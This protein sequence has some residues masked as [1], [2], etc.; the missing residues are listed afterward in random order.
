MQ[1]IALGTANRYL[2]QT[3]DIIVQLLEAGIIPVFLLGKV[4]FEVEPFFFRRKFIF[5]RECVGLHHTTVS[6]LYG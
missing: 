4:V 3:T 6:Q 5:S 2:W 1:G